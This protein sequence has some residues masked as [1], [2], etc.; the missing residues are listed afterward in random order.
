[1]HRARTSGPMRRMGAP[2]AYPA[3]AGGVRRAAPQVASFPTTV[4]VGNLSWDVTWQDL[5]D[6]M[7]TAGI[8]VVRVEIPTNAEGKS[9]GFALIQFVSPVAASAAIMSFNN[10]E[11]KGRPMF[12]R[13]DR[14]SAAPAVMPMMPAA[15]PM[16]H[17]PVH[18]AP[19]AQP[20]CSVYVG[21]LSWDVTWKELKDAMRA[22][23]EVVHADVVMGPDGRSKG[24]GV[25]QFAS[26]GVAAQA[27]A[28]LNGRDLK[29][30]PMMLREDRDAGRGPQPGCGMYVGNLAWEVT[31]QDLKDHVRRHGVEAVHAEVIMGPDGRSRGFGIVQF[32]T[33][34]LTAQAIAAVN[35]TELKGRQLFVREDRDGGVAAGAGA[36]A[37]TME[38]VVTTGTSVHV[39][40][41]SW[42]ATDEDVEAALSS[43]GHIV[44][45]S[46]ARMSDG[47]SKGF[48]VV[49]FESAESATYA[50]AALNGAD[51]KGR[52]INLRKK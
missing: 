22:A 25:V 52:A 3:M 48:G 23:G 51:I 35:D 33:P 28:S 49:E 40:N 16:R 11:Y 8:D 34:E 30:R 37:G 24:F 39:G 29:G 2:A 44:H 18:H 12:F 50:I 32:A 26:A 20:G 9:K 38:E 13:L 19:P 17:V 1:M 10:T 47:R 42:E 46:V 21:N 43:A 45:C 4:F 5:K 6:L 31:W 41:L 36:G 14:D 27:I 15:A 7:R